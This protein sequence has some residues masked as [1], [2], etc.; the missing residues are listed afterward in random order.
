M[1]P[2]PLVSRVLDDEGLTADL[3]G[4]AAET[5]VRWLVARVEAVA[6]TA[7]SEAVA[8]REVERLCC[9]ARDVARFVGR[10]VVDVD[11]A[12]PLQ[13][14]HPHWPVPTDGEDAASLLQRILDSEGADRP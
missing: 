8:R 3:E 6:R 12:R 9:A 2:Q 7:K 11:A 4:D 10:W 1:D 14:S 13:A 5:L